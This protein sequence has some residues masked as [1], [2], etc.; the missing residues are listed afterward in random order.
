MRSLFQEVLHLFTDGKERTRYDI[1]EELRDVYGDFKAFKDKQMDEALHTAMSNG[2]IAESNYEI[3]VKK[4]DF[5]KY[6]QDGNL[7]LNAE[8]KPDVKTIETKELVM[9]YQSDQEMIDLINS[10]IK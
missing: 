7:I 4:Q 2:L 3:W 8:G 10:Y 9:Y 5:L 6:G 1:Q